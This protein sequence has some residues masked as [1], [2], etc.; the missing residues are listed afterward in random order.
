MDI[1]TQKENEIREIKLNNEMKKIEN[2]ISTENKY[3][4]SIN[5][6]SL[7]TKSSTELR[8]I[9]ENN[10]LEKEKERV[11]KASLILRKKN[12]QD[13]FNIILN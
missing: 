4:C 13:Y 10:L 7:P 6:G 2:V 5:L 11:A 3:R 12:H 8:V 1:K 9:A